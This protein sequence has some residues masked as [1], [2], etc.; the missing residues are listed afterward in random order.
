MS[1]TPGPSRPAADIG[2][3][4][5]FRVGLDPGKWSLGSEPTEAARS[6]DQF[7]LETLGFRVWGLR[8]GV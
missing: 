2:L 3:G 7:G 4:F 6:R 5:R 8:F 1:K